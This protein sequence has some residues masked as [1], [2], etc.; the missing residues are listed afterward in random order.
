MRQEFI[1][2]LRQTPDKKVVFLGVSTCPLAQFGRLQG[3]PDALGGSYGFYS[4]AV[5]Y[6]VL[7]REEH[8]V[9]VHADTYHQT[10]GEVADILEAR[11]L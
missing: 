4:K 2:W 9:L 8:M 11:T 3:Y 7:N 10:Y 5:H 1:N 6:D